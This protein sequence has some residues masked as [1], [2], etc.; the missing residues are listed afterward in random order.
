[1]PA[2]SNSGK[3]MSLNVI[4]FLLYWTKWGF[5]AFRSFS[6]GWVDPSWQL[7]THKPLVRSSLLC[8]KGE[9][10][11]RKAK[12]KRVGQ[13][14]D[15][16]IN[17]GEEKG[18]GDLQVIQRQSLTISHQQTDAKSIPKQQLLWKNYPVFVADHGV[19]SV[20]YPF[21]QLGSAVPAASPPCLLPTPASFS[22]L[23]SENRALD[24]GPALLSNV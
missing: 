4:L 1:M 6:I 16:W 5:F 24:A 13:D 21:G 11:K 15:I 18:R 17:Q 12:K 19:R 14:K 7:R 3:I 9:N 22:E 20:E 23:Q 10:W 8:A 2:A